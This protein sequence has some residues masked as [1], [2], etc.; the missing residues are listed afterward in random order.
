MERI[1]L[2]TK[3]HAGRTQKQANEK[4]NQSVSVL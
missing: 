1:V 2:H 4:H 3:R